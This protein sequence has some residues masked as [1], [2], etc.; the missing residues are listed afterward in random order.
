MKLKKL[1]VATLAVFFSLSATGVAVAQDEPEMSDQEM[2]ELE[3]EEAGMMSQG[4]IRD[5]VEQCLEEVRLQNEMEE[6]A[7]DWQ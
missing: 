5:Y 6:S 3:A 2:C 7:S 4:D 1:S